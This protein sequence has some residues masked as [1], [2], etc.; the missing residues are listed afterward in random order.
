MCWNYQKACDIIS[1]LQ[2]FNPLTS[3]IVY[4]ICSSILSFI[5]VYLLK[6]M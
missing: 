5:I 1:M 3:F 6:T 2:I 4:L